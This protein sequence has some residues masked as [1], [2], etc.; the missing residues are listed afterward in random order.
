[1]ETS[2]AAALLDSLSGRAHEFERPSRVRSGRRD[3]HSSRGV[4]TRLWAMHSSDSRS[5]GLGSLRFGPVQLTRG[6][7]VVGVAVLVLLTSLVVAASQLTGVTI[8][9]P[10][11]IEDR[12][13]RIDASDVSGLDAATGA[14]GRA[15][16]GGR[17]AEAEAKGST[18]G[19]SSEGGDDDGRTSQSTKETSGA[20][21]SN[22]DSTITVHVAGAVAS[23]G[24]VSLAASSR[25]VDA[26]A[27]AGGLRSDADPDR[28]N[29]A[30]SLSDGI[31]VVVPI[32]GQA[33][34]AEVPLESAGSSGGA[35]AVAGTG[36]ASGSKATGANGGQSVNINT[37][38]DQELQALPGVGPSTSAAIVAHRE[39]SGPFRSVEGLLDVRGIGEAKLD[40]M[41]DMVTIG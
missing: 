28:I 35:A 20:D 33:L 10:A 3:R 17:T 1:M 5:V 16:A 2:R 38:S 25:V 27:A 6:G 34:P 31:K 37:A 22:A 11:P 19:G 32:K 15:K 41:R 13:R 7:V 9:R 29:L 40:A 36:T 24:V 23:P 14:N 21:I 12:M 30:A 26:V 4:R 18:A 8:A 39:K